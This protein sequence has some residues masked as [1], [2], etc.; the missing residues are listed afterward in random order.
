MEAGR[1]H[2]RLGNLNV[3][4]L[5]LAMHP[6][7]TGPASLQPPSLSVWQTVQLLFQVCA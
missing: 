3:Q 4:M 7:V 1:A 2:G 5:D 6:K